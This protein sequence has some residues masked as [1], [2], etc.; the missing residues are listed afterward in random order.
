[1]NSKNREQS[2]EK[3]VN[4]HPKSNSCFTNLNSYPFVA[5]CN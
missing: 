2:S 4:G 3:Q 1:M 5:T